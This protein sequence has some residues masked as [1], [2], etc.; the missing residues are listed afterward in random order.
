MVEVTPFSF[1]TFPRNPSGRSST[2]SRQPNGKRK[3]QSNRKAEKPKQKK[4][5]HEQT[6]LSPVIGP[7]NPHPP[8]QSFLVRC[9]TRAKPPPINDHR[10][11]PPHLLPSSQLE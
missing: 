3:K 11:S 10:S 7:C 1:V 2:S 8:S 5:N 4:E 6:K 9:T